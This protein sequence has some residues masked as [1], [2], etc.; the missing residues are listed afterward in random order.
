MELGV[1]TVL[2]GK[3]T[4]ITKFGAF[5]ALPEGKTGLVHIS[6]IS[7]SYVND[8]REHLKE[9]QTVKVKIIGIDANNRINLSIKKTL[10]PPPRSAE[11]SRPSAHSSYTPRSAAPREPSSFEDKIKQFMQDSD[12]KMSDLKQYIDKRSGSSRRRGK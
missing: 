3:V 10:E 2:E 7:H 6:E 9:G 4:G 5:V 12:S 11:H 8:I 1:G